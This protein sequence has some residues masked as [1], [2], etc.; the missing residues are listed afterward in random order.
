MIEKRGRRKGAVT[1]CSISYKQLGE[2]IGAKGMIPVKKAWLETL[3][4]PFGDESE[5]EESS[6]V[7]QE[8]KQELP[9]IKYEVT[10]FEV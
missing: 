2:Y 4:F 3:G 9:K 5:Q 7:K 1:F 10:E 8:A 6:C